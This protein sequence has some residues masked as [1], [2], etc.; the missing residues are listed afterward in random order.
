MARVSGNFIL[1][2]MRGKIGKELVIKQYGSKTVVTKYP[3]MSN[4]KP[5]DLQT[6]QRIRFA[7]AVAYAKAINNNPEQKAAY[8]KKVK[9]RESVYQYAIKEF[10]K[11]NP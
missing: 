8:Q 2:G 6:N 4:V 10:L 9:Q 1:K 5:S 3:D 7:D 11:N